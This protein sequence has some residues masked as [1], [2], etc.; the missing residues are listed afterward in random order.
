[1]QSINEYRVLTP[2]GMS[3]SHLLPQPRLG[4]H[5]RRRGGKIVKS[6]AGEDSYKVSLNTKGA[7][8][9]MNQ[10]SCDCG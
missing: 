4:E 2:N 5:C 7:I 8:A 9:L 6:E 1:M 3:I 10:G